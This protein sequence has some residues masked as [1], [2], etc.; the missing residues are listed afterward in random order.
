MPVTTYSSQWRK[1]ALEDEHLRLLYLISRYTSES[2]WIREWPLL[3]LIFEGIQAGVFSYDYAPDAVTIMGRILF[4]NISQEGRD[5]MDDLR[6]AGLLQSLKLTTY[7]GS[8]VTALKLSDEG[9]EWLGHV[10][11]ADRQVVDDF[12]GAD[13]LMRVVYSAGRFDI[14]EGD[15]EPR[16]SD[17]LDC[18]DVSY[19]CSP[20]V[21]D[22]V[23]PA[24]W[25]GF[26]EPCSDNSERAHLSNT[27]G[28]GLSADANE[29]VTL[30]GV[31]ILVGEWIPFGSNQVVAMNNRLGS[32]ERCQGG[33]LTAM[34]DDD[35]EGRKDMTFVQQGESLTRVQ[36]LDFTLQEHINFEAEIHYPEDEGIVQIEHVGVSVNSGGSVHYGCVL[37]SVNDR[38][39][40]HSISLDLLARV[41]A[42]LKQDTSQLIDD[43][44][45]AY[46]RDLLHLVYG[47]VSN[48]TQ[49]GGGGGADASEESADAA[50]SS[51]NRFKYVVLVCDSITPSGEAE[52][53]MD[54]EDKE[55]ELKQVVGDTLAAFDIGSDGVLILGTA[56]MLYSLGRSGAPHRLEIERI[57]TLHLRLSALSVFVRNFFTRTFALDAEIKTIQEMIA[58]FDKDPTYMIKIRTR[59]T[60]AGE[61]IT[62]LEEVR[63]YMHEM[64][65]ELR[66]PLS[67][68][69]TVPAMLFDRLRIA[70]SHATI[71]LRIEDLQKN[72]E[73]AASSVEGLRKQCAVISEKQLFKF[74]ESMQSANK[75]LVSVF[76]SNEKAGTAQSVMEV[77]TMGTLAFAILDRV[78]GGWSMIGE[79]GS[80][81]GR[82]VLA[83]MIETVPMLWFVVNM[84]AWLVMGL[85]LYRYMQ[86]LGD[87]ADDVLLMQLKPLN[88]KLR[89][90]DRLRDYVETKTITGES[91][92]LAGLVHKRNLTWE[93]DSTS[94][95]N[96]RHWYGSP[97]KISLQCD[98]ANEFLLGATLE[99]KDKTRLVETL[100]KG[101][102]R[103]TAAAGGG[104]GHEQHQIDTDFGL[105]ENVLK[106]T[107]F[108][109][110]VEAGVLEREVMEILRSEQE[111]IAN[112]TRWTVPGEDDWL[113]E[114]EDGFEDESARAWSNRGN[115][116]KLQ[117]GTAS[118]GTSPRKAN[119]GNNRTGRPI[120]Q[121]LQSTGS[122]SLGSSVADERE[123]LS[124]ASRAASVAKS[125]TQQAEKEL[126]TMARELSARRAQLQ[127]AEEE[128]DR[129]V[130]Q[131]IRG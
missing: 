112:P 71:K 75:N 12:Y 56:G 40:G 22:C 33:F 25:G 121:S 98:E 125:R 54:K 85:V 27:G 17:V 64:I 124:R 81:W 90:I 92:E 91:L 3:V 83:P 82:T 48:R 44:I 117:P 11:D 50:D 100:S 34:M 59:L 80:S 66:V 46:Q 70:H 95:E 7:A 39:D 97:P 18:E 72:V 106:T 16:E 19:V 21:P 24:N 51:V 26:L 76:R 43:L 84:G 89:S 130:Q 9:W 113:A 128:A 67:P 118:P 101:R 78:T 131:L 126:Q 37:H 86:R 60:Q 49:H 107:F 111:H 4:M 36:L 129:L 102:L 123:A 41:L 68:D 5:D 28:T 127:Q 120:P 23:R 1:D 15:L 77:I 99:F 69:S 94:E 88:L 57:L 104:G 109:E 110:L 114:E 45:S 52:S 103:P 42:D 79:E 115:P 10:K 65:T 87:L 73:A 74:Q 58:N 96:L 31:S 13:D 122:R 116:A 105:V 2:R 30:A 14:V 47:S 108:Q 8:T 93:V 29:V 20:F 63:G 32:Q 119:A 6:E 55:N 38:V 61:T 53:Y 62:S 35:S